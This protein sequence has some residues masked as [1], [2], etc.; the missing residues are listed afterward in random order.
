LEAVAEVLTKAKAQLL[1]DYLAAL[2]E[3][4]LMQ[5]FVEV[6]PQDKVSLV[7]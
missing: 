5:V 1:A 2:A 3:G 4:L 6:T 7:E